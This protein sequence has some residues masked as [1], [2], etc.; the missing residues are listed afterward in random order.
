MHAAFRRADLW[1]GLVLIALAAV[2][3][4]GTAHLPQ[5]SLRAIGAGFFPL[6]LASLTGLIG[7]LL[8]AKAVVHATD[9]MERWNPRPALLL[10]LA[11]GAFGLLVETAGLA[12]AVIVCGAIAGFAGDETRPRELLLFLPLA[13]LFSVAA[14]VWALGVPIPV[15]PASILSWLRP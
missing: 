6:V 4:R 3:W 1:S 11:T 10:A 2:I 15:A 9:A 8:L 12:L 14:F 13:A 7:M 5:G